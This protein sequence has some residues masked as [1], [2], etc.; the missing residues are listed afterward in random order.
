MEWERCV[1]NCDPD[2]PIVS[3][4]MLYQPHFSYNFLQFLFKIHMFSINNIFPTTHSMKSCVPVVLCCEQNDAVPSLLIII[5]L[6]FLFL[7]FPH[8]EQNSVFLSTIFSPQ[9]TI[10]SLYEMM[11]PCCAVFMKAGAE[12]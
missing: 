4:I 10:I 1:I 7:K 3:K 8:F 11:C 6:Q 5:F 12:R 2:P 9:L